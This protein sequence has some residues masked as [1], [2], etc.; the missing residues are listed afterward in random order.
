MSVDYPNSQYG[1]ETHKPAVDR[2]LAYL[3]RLFREEPVGASAAVGL[4]FGG[5]ANSGIAM[6][7]GTVAAFVLTEPL[8]RR[9][10]PD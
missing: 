4:M 8:R 5:I 6:F 2:L 10:S 3:A 9:R 1:D 7:L